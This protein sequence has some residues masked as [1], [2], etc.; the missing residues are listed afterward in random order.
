LDIYEISIALMEGV[1][2]YAFREEALTG[3]T[4]ARGKRGTGGN[5]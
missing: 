1:G 4:E 3:G 5:K 2:K